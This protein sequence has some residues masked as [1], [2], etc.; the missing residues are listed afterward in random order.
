VIT[1]AEYCD[2]YCH[3]FEQLSVTIF[4]AIVKDT[5]NRISKKEQLM[6]F[7]QLLGATPEFAQWVVELATKFTTQKI[8]LNYF[9]P[10]PKKGSRNLFHS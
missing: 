5:L 2:G 6:R 10:P 1:R 4:R 3:D 9:F 7:S 8:K